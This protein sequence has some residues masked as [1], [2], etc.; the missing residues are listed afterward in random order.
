VEIVGDKVEGSKVLKMIEEFI[1]VYISEDLMPRL[2]DV[3]GVT[4]LENLSQIWGQI[5]IYA[6]SFDRLFAYINRTYL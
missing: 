2:M 6:I 1:R 4:L 3:E 5:C